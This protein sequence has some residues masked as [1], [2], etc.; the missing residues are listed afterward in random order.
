MIKKP[1]FFVYYIA[2]LI[3]IY[4]SKF[5][6]NNKYIRNELLK[7]KG[8]AIVLCDHVS[9]HDQVIAIAACRRRM[10]FVI[11]DALYYSKFH[12]LIKSIN[13]IRKQQ[14]YTKIDEIKLMKEVVDNKGILAM[15]PAG[16][17][18]SDGINTTIP[19]AT[20]KFIKLLGVDVYILNSHGMYLS[21]HKWNKGICKGKTE[22][23]VFK[24]LDKNQLKDLSSKEIYEKVNEAMYC[25][26]YSWQEKNMIKF[27]NGNICKGLENVLYSCP[28][29][30]THFSIKNINNT[31][32]CNSCHSVFKLND[33]SLF[34]SE[35]MPSITN[36]YL[37]HRILIEDIKK[38][39]SDDNF[40]YQSKCLIKKLNKEKCLFENIGN[41]V[42]SIDKN[43]IVISINNEEIYK[44]P[45]IRF[46]VL[47]M[48]PGEYFDLHDG[49]N[50]YRCIPEIK[51]DVSYITDI[52]ICNYENNEIK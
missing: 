1:N 52:V 45:T 4:K 8:P 37:W 36:S 50:I 46:F 39:V 35:D 29:C 34:E 5:K 26:E 7:A 28:K 43:Y 49:V 30:L 25:N 22:T 16:V 19:K 17:C 47:P 40:L 2:R 42:V 23:D 6:L 14:M 31:L 15:F 3:A 12:K 13:V 20:G 48:I 11:A 51:Q 32:E 18:S 41:G 9:C 44:V 38:K 27:K 21:S 24:L 10:N 33:Y